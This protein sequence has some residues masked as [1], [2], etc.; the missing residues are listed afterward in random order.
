MPFDSVAKRS[1]RDLLG[2]LARAAALVRERDLLPPAQ[3]AFLETPGVETPPAELDALRSRSEQVL[4]AYLAGSGDSDYAA[5]RYVE[6]ILRQELILDELS[7]IDPN[8]APLLARLS[9]MDRKR[10]DDYLLYRNVRGRFETLDSL[11][12]LW[13]RTV[14]WVVERGDTYT[15]DE[16]VDRLTSRD[17]LAEAVSVLSPSSRAALDRRVTALDQRFLD[18]TRAVSDSIRPRVPWRPQ[19]WWWFR[20][21]LVLGQHFQDRL[22]AQGF[23]P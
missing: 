21:P 5:L 19:R 23:S 17:S 9:G 20:V 3:A 18:A 13:E 7:S 12:E 14:D 6:A 4:R 1:S 8:G 2:I 11:V 22:A 16:Y 10:V 15:H